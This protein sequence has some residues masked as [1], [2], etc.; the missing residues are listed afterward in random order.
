F[1][2]ANRASAPAVEIADVVGHSCAGDR[3]LPFAKVP[4]IDEGD[5][6]AILDTGAYDESSAS[7]FNALPRPATILVRGDEAEV[8]RRAETLED[9]YRRDVVPARLARSHDR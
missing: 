7:N 8:I 6:I 9:L 4:H 3:I 2:V 5:V 1:R